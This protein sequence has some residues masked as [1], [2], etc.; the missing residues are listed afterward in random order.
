MTLRIS[1]TCDKFAKN[2]LYIIV[3]FL[4]SKVASNRSAN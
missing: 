4:L 2:F 3:I 1:I